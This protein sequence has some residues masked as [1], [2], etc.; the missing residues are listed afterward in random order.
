MKRSKIYRPEIEVEFVG[1]KGFIAFLI[2]IC[3]V[4]L[5]K[6]VHIDLQIKTF[7]PKVHG[8]EGGTIKRIPYYIIPKYKLKKV[9]KIDESE[10][11]EE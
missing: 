6:K 8:V 2:A 10:V 4:G 1:V 5:I 11:A 9:A 3:K 7:T